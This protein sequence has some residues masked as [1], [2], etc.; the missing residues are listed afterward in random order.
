VFFNVSFPKSLLFMVILTDFHGFPKSF[1]VNYGNTMVDH[2]DLF[3]NLQNV[4][5]GSCV[6]PVFPGL[7]RPGHETEHSPP[8]TVEVK[9]EL[10][11]PLLPL[12]ASRHRL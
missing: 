4:P 12:F 9:N 6:H 1:Q 7:M 11:I 2:D 10:T 3:L 8:S 5:T